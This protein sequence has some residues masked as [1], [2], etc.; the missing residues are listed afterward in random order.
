MAGIIHRLD[1]ASYD[2]YMLRNMEIP[3]LWF[4]LELEFPTE[5]GNSNLVDVICVQ[6]GKA[7]FYFL[8]L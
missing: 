6:D 5:K 1:L 8:R 2:P 4:D 7:W 3:V